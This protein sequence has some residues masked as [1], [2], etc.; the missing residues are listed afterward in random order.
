MWGV[1]N[2]GLKKWVTS[3]KRLKTIDI[4]NDVSFFGKPYNTDED[5]NY[6][7]SYY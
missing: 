1:K 2:V 6:V 7:L 4:D 5:K 3:L